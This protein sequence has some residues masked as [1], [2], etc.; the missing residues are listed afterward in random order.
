MTITPIALCKMAGRFTP[1]IAL[2]SI[3]AILP[4]AD[5]AAQGLPVQ[6]GSMLPVAIWWIGACILGLALAYGI[7]RN[8]RRTGAEKALTERATKDLYAAEDRKEKRD[9]VSTGSV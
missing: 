7:M 4:S 9:R 3:A 1:V 8:R 6:N 5:L 2:S